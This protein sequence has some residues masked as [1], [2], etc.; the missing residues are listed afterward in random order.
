M[1]QKQFD[2]LTRTVSRFP[3]RREM[4]RGLAGAGLGLGALRMSQVEA[5]KNGG[6]GKNKKGAKVTICHQGQTIT[7]S[8]SALKAHLTHG[9]TEGSCPTTNST[10]QTGGPTGPTGQSGP[11]CTDGITNGSET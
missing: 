8:S 5:A 9:D 1:D 10:Q 4:L 3:S 6:K 11:T 7:V 2:A